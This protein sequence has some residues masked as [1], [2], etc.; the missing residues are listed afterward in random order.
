[1][2]VWY[3]STWFS[4]YIPGSPNSA[5]QSLSHHSALQLSLQ[6][7]TGSW[8]P[9]P[10][11]L[12]SCSL[13]TF[14]PCS[15][16][17]RKVEW[18]SSAGS[19]PKNSC[20]KWCLSPSRWSLPALITRLANENFSNNCKILPSSSQHDLYRLVLARWLE[21]SLASLK[22][23]P[24]GSWQSWQLPVWVPA[25]G[26]PL[27]SNFHS[28][29]ISEEENEKYHSPDLSQACQ[30]GIFSKIRKTRYLWQD[31]DEG[32]NW[33]KKNE[34]LEKRWR[35]KEKEI[36]SQYRNR[37]V[38]GNCRKWRRINGEMVKYKEIER[39]EGSKVNG[40]EWKVNIPWQRIRDTWQETATG[41][42]LKWSTLL[43]TS[44]RFLSCFMCTS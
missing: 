16:Y 28:S 33:T 40:E 27:L 14:F 26:I 42:M 31:S 9:L 30:G 38:L 22:S 11:L 12:H 1:M 36:N 21:L 29:A 32:D 13:K 23:V 24:A 7:D 25:K 41:M 18:G 37:I 39:S 10:F 44:G 5:S 3:P 15:S 34:L 35:E 19:C 4:S 8:T 43:C 6:P 17:L 2:V 20:G